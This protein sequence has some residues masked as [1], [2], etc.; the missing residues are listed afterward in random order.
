MISERGHGRLSSPLW[1]I[2]NRRLYQEDW[3][4]F[5]VDFQ[6]LGEDMLPQGLEITHAC[7]HSTLEGP[8]KK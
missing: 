2:L 1:R 6:F 8:A 4:I 5:W 3:V 7:H